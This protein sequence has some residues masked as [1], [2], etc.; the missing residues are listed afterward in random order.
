ME[1][2]N[3]AN[4]I[5]V[6]DKFQRAGKNGTVFCSRD[7]AHEA[8]EGYYTKKQINKTMESRTHGLISNKN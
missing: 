5:H 6:N 3:C 1:C 2:Q 8:F 7:C 4:E